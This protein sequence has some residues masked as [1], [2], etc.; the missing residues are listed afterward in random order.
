MN[1]F[2]KPLKMTAIAVL[3]FLIAFFWFVSCEKEAIA[4][5][6]LEVGGLL[7]SGNPT[8]GIIITNE[9]INDKYAFGIGLTSPQKLNS[10]LYKSNALAQV[11]RYVT[12][13][14]VSLGLGVTYWKNTNPFVEK[15]FSFTE[16]IRYRV[17]NNVDLSYRHW[18]TGGSGW[19][20]F[21]S[22]LIGL[23]W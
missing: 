17:N 23:H 6:T 9:V 7:D 1:I 20:G 19:G 10:V 3:I 11:Q 16:M 22:F 12:Y 15:G 8:G 14:K 18:S 5:T 4:D 21:D 13:K 2:G